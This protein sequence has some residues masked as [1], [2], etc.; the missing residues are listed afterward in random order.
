[1][2]PAYQESSH[3]DFHVIVPNTSHSRRS[4]SKSISRRASHSKSGHSHRARNMRSRSR[5]P[6]LCRQKSGCTTA[7]PPAVQSSKNTSKNQRNPMRRSVS[8]EEPPVGTT[9][10]I[11]STKRSEPRRLRRSSSYDDSAD[12]PVNNTTNTRE[13]TTRRPL[14]VLQVARRSSTATSTHNARPATRPQTR[15]RSKSPIVASRSGNEKLSTASAILS[16]SSETGKT[17]SKTKTVRK[18]PRRTP[19]SEGLPSQSTHSQATN[20]SNTSSSSTAST[21]VEEAARK[22]KDF[23]LQFQ[24]NSRR[25]QKLAASSKEH[26][27][28][29][30]KDVPLL[31]RVK[32]A[33]A[34][35]SSTAAAQSA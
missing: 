30:T 26:Q 11:T 17:K 29:I 20:A 3:E 34:P 6:G 13:G 31:R 32:T 19:T 8:L 2:G 33:P 14:L 23:Q 7:N 4:R 12:A 21:A 9:T 25:Q 10:T 24:K 27:E 1:M 35:K 22:M 5:S 28:T 16:F 15:N 18:G